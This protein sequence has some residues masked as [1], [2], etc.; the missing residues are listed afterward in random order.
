M[1][2]PA[3]I[4][5]RE[6]G[7][8]GH[9]RPGPWAHVCPAPCGAQGSRREARGSQMRGQGGRWGLRPAGPRRSRAERQRG[10]RPERWGW[11]MPA[12]PPALNPRGGEARRRGRGDPRGGSRAPVGGAGPGGA[13][14]GAHTRPVTGG[15]RC[16]GAASSGGG[17]RSSVW[18]R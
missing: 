18:N 16:G 15:G 10:E 14:A 4:W 7:T 3:G 6:G 8:A 9:P 11:R 5:P 1:G 13:A 17:P 2:A 12:R